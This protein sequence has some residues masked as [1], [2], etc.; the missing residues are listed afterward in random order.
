[1][2]AFICEIVEPRVLDLIMLVLPKWR[3]LLY[4]FLM[5][6]VLFTP[7][8]AFSVLVIGDTDLTLICPSA[9]LYGSNLVHRALFRRHNDGNTRTLL[10]GV[11]VLC[12]GISA[13]GLAALYAPTPAP[14][15]LL[16][17]GVVGGYGYQL[18]FSKMWKVLAKAFSA[19]KEMFVIKFL[20]S[21]GQACSLLLLLACLHVPWWYREY[22]Y[23]ALLLVLTGL[24]LHL[25]PL[26]LLIENEKNWLKLDLDS[27]VQLTEKGNERYY[28]RVA[29]VRTGTAQLSQVPEQQQ[30]QQQQ[31]QQRPQHSPPPFELLPVPE[32]FEPGSLGASWKNPATFTGLI[33]QQQSSS[34]G[35]QYSAMPLTD[36]DNDAKDDG[37]QLYARDGKCFNQDGVEI[38]EVILEED[39]E[40]IRQTEASNRADGAAEAIKQEC[41]IPTVSDTAT[42]KWNCLCS[43]LLRLRLWPSTACSNGDGHRWLN[44]RLV[45][46][47]KFALLDLRCYGCMLLRAT[48]TCMFVLFLAIL[49]RYTAHQQHQQH[50]QQHQPSGISVRLLTIRAI[51]VIATAWVACSL[52]LLCCDVRFRKQQNRLLIFGILFK[53]FGYFCVYASLRF[54]FWTVAGCVLVGFGHSIA[55]AYQDLVIKRQFTQ[56]QWQTAKAGLCLLTG[57]AVV[58]LAGAAN[59]LYLHA[60]I[61]H[62]LLALLLVYCAAGVFWMACNCRVFFS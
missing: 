8:Y 43:Q 17:Y 45:R 21:C 50:L 12:A 3:L 58:L 46:S 41:C 13:S 2:E 54:S 57:L 16:L 37:E 61:D 44:R 7:L 25:V 62:L 10:L 26:A 35:A 20:H 48:D 36:D 6:M 52:L 9:M 49:P 28:G 51:G 15:V 14:V 39:E 55:C 22:V 23:G 59:L 53:S 11:G 19:R 34:S 60:R 27:L 24:V 42:G 18:V 29:G 31:Q 47:L 40:S 56:A 38:L 33:G 30:Q 4:I 32:R 1:M 5:N